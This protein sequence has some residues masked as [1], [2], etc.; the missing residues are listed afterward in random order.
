MSN[1]NYESLKSLLAKHGKKQAFYSFAARF[2]LKEI[3]FGR[4]EAEILLTKI[5][6]LCIRKS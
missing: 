3:N 6:K 4:M 1:I 2:K 5:D